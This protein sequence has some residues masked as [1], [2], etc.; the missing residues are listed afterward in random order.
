MTVRALLAIRILCTLK[1]SSQNQINDLYLEDGLYGGWKYRDAST[2]Y[3][4][5]TR[6]CILSAAGVHSESDSGGPSRSGCAGSQLS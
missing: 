6:I 3:V 4:L 2:P 5:P 1:I